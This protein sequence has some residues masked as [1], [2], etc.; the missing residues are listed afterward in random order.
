MSDPEVELIV[1]D[2]VCV[3]CSRWVRF[4]IAR[5]APRRYRFAAMQ[6]PVGRLLLRQH[7]LDPDDPSSFLL[8]DG[9]R[10][11]TGSDAIIHVVARFG[12]PWRAAAMARIVP[13]A[14]R[15]GLYRY[16]ARRRYRWFGKRDSC[17]LPSAEIAD[18][19]LR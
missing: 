9:C 13:R 2:G 3:L 4:I 19:F 8:L 16:L 7:G 18:R 5:D 10:P 1:F 15:D 11:R 6:S 14:L 17:G 12:G